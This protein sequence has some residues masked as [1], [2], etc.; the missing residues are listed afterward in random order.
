VTSLLTREI[1]VLDPRTGETVGRVPIATPQQC[2]DALRRAR[3][4]AGAWAR[5]PA[6]ERAAAL[7][8]AAAAV[9]DA[10]DELAALNTRETG[11]PPGDARGGVVSTPASARSSSTPSSVPSTGAA[12]C[13]GPGT[14]RTS[15]SPARAGSSPS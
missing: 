15:W 2:D 13:T 8:A 14:R 6:A 10:A 12:A 9:R 11:K 7:H 5:T 4:A 3:A 1:T